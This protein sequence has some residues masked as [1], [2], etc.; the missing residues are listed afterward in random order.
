M[1]VPPHLLRHTVTVEPYLGEGGA[2][3]LYG[4]A[5]TVRCHLSP[6]GRSQR[7]GADREQRD[8]TTCVVQV[9]D[10]PL[11]AEDARITV[12]GRRVEV[13][14]RREHTF[15]GTQAPEHVEVTLT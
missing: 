3:P 11:L 14:S 10:G 8:T 15:P 2:G 5:V 13:S 4:P 1:R 6:G 12:A 9:E 7:R